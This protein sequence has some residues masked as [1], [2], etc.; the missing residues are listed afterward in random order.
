M[1]IL[2]IDYHRN[3][4]CGEG[5]HAV[6]FTDVV[7]ESGLPR[8]F[9]A[10]VFDRAVYGVVCV[11]YLAEKGVGLGNHWRGD[12]YIDRLWR[13]IKKHRATPGRYRARVAPR[14]DA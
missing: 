8:E 11:D 5:F 2:E 6:R 10:M 14:P 3:G 13:A 7:D 9:L 4:V 12:Y 1:K